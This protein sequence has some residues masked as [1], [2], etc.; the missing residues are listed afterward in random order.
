MTWVLSS[1]AVIQVLATN[2]TTGKIGQIYYNSADKALMQYDGTE[3]LTEPNDAKDALIVYTN[4]KNFINGVDS[5][6]KI[7]LY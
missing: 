5:W 2:P 1:N 3:Y 6:D 4:I 7:K